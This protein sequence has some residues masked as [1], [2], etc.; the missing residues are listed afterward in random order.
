MEEETKKEPEQPE[1]EGFLDKAKK[2]FKKADK[3]IDEKVDKAKQS[4]AYEEVSEAVKKAEDFVEDKIE[5][6]KKL[7]SS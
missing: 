6:I 5:D 2:L 1:K 7:L 3:F 4:K